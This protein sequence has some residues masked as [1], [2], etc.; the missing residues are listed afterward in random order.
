MTE[1]L[2][3]LA[4]YVG[5]FAIAFVAASLFPAQSE[6]VFAG[7]LF[8]GDYDPAMLLLSATAG[9]T[10]GSLA[11]WLI[12]RFVEH[13]RDR[14]WFPFSAD[15][16]QRAERWY[17]KW[18]KWSLLL[19]WAPILGDVLTLAAGMMRLRLAVFLPLVIL[20]KGGRYLAI[21]MGVFWLSKLE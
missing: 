15:A 8:A 3:S 18:G 1:I 2:A 6:V 16:I 5:L 13:F 19:S 14:K 4:P 11:N 12:G 21:L 10:L 7:M 20:A 9:N 17:A